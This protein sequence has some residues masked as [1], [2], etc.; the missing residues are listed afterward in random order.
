MVGLAENILNLF[1]CR[2]NSMKKKNGFTLLELLLAISLMG[3]LAVLATPM[4]LSLQAENEMSI[5]AITIEDILHR[6]Q[7][8]SQAV[9]G[10]SAWGVNIKTGSLII[11][12]GQNFINRDQAF[13]ENYSLTGAVD[14]SGT[15]EIIFSPLFGTPN[16]V[17]TIQ[18]AHLDGRQTELSVNGM[19]IINNP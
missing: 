1:Q 5:T 12:K 4:Y 16:I 7:L 13:D 14:L 10:D 3:I 11:F 9:D 8:K 15:T 17:G 19:G 18:L 6:A 2:L